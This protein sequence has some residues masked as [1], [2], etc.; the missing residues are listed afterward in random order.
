[1]FASERGQRFAVAVLAGVGGIAVVV[2]YL[3][4]A[5]RRNRRVVAECARRLTSAT[6][7]LPPFR[8]LGRSCCPNDREID[9]ACWVP[10]PTGD[11][12]LG[13]T[14]RRTDRGR[15][16]VPRL[17][18]YQPYLHRHQ[19]PAPPSGSASAGQRFSVAVLAGVGGIAVVARYVGKATA[20]TVA[21]SLGC[22]TRLTSVTAV[23]AAVPVPGQV[24]LPELDREIDIACR[25]PGPAGDRC[26]VTH[27]RTDRGRRDRTC[28][29]RISRTYRHGRRHHRRVQLLR[30]QRFA[31]A[32]LA[33]VGG[34]AVV[35]RYEE[36]TRRDRCVVARM[37]DA[38]DQRDR[39][40]CCCPA[41]QVVLP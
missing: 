14:H 15:L 4:K 12:R 3:G 28:A 9:I 10:A 29:G 37:R 16:I 26:L 30:G 11:R 22:A 7:F 27:R 2:R 25:R 8:F 36:A 20:G 23:P 1:M 6:P 31:V 13:A 24:A 21:S 39:R 34:I 35:V 19:S 33:G 38:T 41:G 17:R 5:T 32:V 40:S 18:P